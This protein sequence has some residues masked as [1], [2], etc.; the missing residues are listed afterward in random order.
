MVQHEGNIVNTFAFV[1]EGSSVSLVDKEL[2]EELGIKG[3][4]CPLSIKW[5]DHHMKESS[6]LASVRATRTSD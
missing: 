4:P 1:D 2:A 3:N 6:V 5:T